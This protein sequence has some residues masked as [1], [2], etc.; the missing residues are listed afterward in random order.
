[1]EETPPIFQEAA[2]CAVC[3]SAFS[4]FRRR[5]HCRCCG[6]S[7]CNEH[8][9]NQMA[10]PQFGVKSAVR[11]CDECFQGTKQINGGGGVPTAI[12][13]AIATDSL[14]RLNLSSDD[15]PFPAKETASAAP[16]AQLQ[17]CTCGMP[18]CICQLPSGTPVVPDIPVVIPVISKKLPAIPSEESSSVKRIPTRPSY[19]NELPSLF[20]STAKSSNDGGH[21]MVKKYEST[22]EGIWEAI[23]NGDT[24]AVKD[25]LATGVDPNYRDKQGMSLLHLAAV[26]NCTEI[27]FLLMDAGANVA[28]KNAQAATCCSNNMC[29]ETCSF[30]DPFHRM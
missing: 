16:V 19:G 2:R 23:K 29:N 9:S 7:L 30:L 25:L 24:A 14:A 15:S 6:K 10:L 4:T 12:N 11:V 13:K 21:F 17:E 3:G 26:F 18:L 20:F 8:S 1:M 27:V 22:G 28:A 5:H